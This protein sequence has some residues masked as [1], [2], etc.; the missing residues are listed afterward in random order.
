MNT[1]TNGWGKKMKKITKAKRLKGYGD[2]VEGYVHD[3]E[4]KQYVLT[5]LAQLVD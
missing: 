3:V 2:F 1:S 4:G 5:M